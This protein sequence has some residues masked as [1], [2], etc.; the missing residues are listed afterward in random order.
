M[1]VYDTTMPDDPQQVVPVTASTTTGSTP[2]VKRRKLTFG[3]FRA[4][5]GCPRRGY[6]GGQVAFVRAALTHKYTSALNGRGTG[7]SVS[8]EILH[9]EEARLTRGTYTDVYIAQGHP[10]AEK[11]FEKYVRLCEKA[12]ILTGRKN[13]GQDRWATTRAFGL[14]SGTE[15]HFWSGEEGALA[16]TRGVRANG[17][18]VDEAGFVHK[19]VVP[20]CAPMLL[21]RQGKFRALGTASRGGC[22]T[23][24]FSD[25][26]NKGVEG[27][28]HYNPSYASFN[29]P[30]ESNPYITDD[31][32]REMR[33]LFRDPNNP[34][35]K[36]SEEAEECDGAFVSDLGACFRNLNAT[37]SLPY[38]RLEPGYYVGL[39]ENGN[40]IQPI[41][42]RRYV[43]GQDWGLKNDNSVSSVFDRV[44]KNQVA[45]R[46][47]PTNRSYDEYVTRLDALHSHWNDALII[48]D[49]RD[50]AGYAQK[51]LAEKYGARYRGIALTPG[52]ENSK[53]G[54]VAR[55]KDLFD[56]STWHFLAVP[57]QMEQFQF[58]AQI[59]I[60]EHSNGYRYEGTSGKHDDIVL[61]AL[62]ASIVMQIETKAPRPTARLIEPLSTEWFQMKAK[63]KSRRLARAGF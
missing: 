44:T 24:W 26:F 55:M 28:K 41:P 31:E 38:R 30:I 43:I 25:M 50:A 16:N 23:G 59:P 51:R 42:G 2:V 32:C 57:E 54:H 18:T 20:T 45:L 8:A 19:I 29:F 11:A 7:K 62:F 33:L 60:G 63:E 1:G 9:W 58:F 17:I 5:A 40:V 12:N 36:T 47:E 49:S 35:V 15:R 22:G 13:K 34:D 3:N 6:P 10:Q 14:N 48:A 37:I 27:S 46:V 61:A 39:D 4:H 21:A 56:L 52:G 53:G